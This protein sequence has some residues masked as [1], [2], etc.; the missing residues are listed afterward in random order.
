MSFECGA[1]DFDICWG[2]EAV[3]G[4]VDT[5]G[6]AAKLAAVVVEGHKLDTAGADGPDGLDVALEGLRVD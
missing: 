5:G 1:Q 6:R 3:P 2:P 4:P